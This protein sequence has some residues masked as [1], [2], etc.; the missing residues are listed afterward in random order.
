[1]TGRTVLC[2]AAH[3]DDEVLGAGG[4]L[5][6]HAAAGHEVH[7]LIV[8]EGVTAQYDDLELVEEKVDAAEECGERLGVETLHFG[9]LPDMRLD[10][11]P[12]VEVNAVIEDCVE[13]IGPDVVYTHTQDDVNQDHVAVAESTMVAVRPGAGVERILAY[14][15][16]SG[17][18]WAAGDRFAPTVYVDVTDHLD[19]KVGAFD[20]YDMERRPYPHPRSERAVRA[21]ARTRGTEAGF[22]AA[23]AFA[24]LREYA[25][26]V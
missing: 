13:S 12:H 4:T 2:V 25:S 11:T 1:M 22:E 7:V 20:A 23:E 18:E 14:E 16:P 5:A 26:E 24:L 21:R 6:K 17:T 10:S 8:T 19:T 9:E 3:P 15:T